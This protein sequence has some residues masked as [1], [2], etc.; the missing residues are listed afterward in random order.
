MKS[1][2]VCISP[3]LLHLYKLE[4]KIVVVVDILRA[5][6]CMTTAFANGV[7]SIIPVASLEE[8][9]EYKNK[10]F[11]AAAE[12]EGKTAEGFDLGNSPFSYMDSSFKGKTIVVTTTNGT[13]AITKSR[14]ATLVMIGS[15]LNKTAIIK[16][17]AKQERHVLVLCSGWRGSFNMEDTLFAG[18]LVSGLEGVYRHESDSALMAKRIYESARYNMMQ[19][20]EDSTHFKRLARLNNYKDIEFCLTED[21]YDILI[22]E[23]DGALVKL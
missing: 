5:T 9:M 3:D 21:L 7:Q 2:D 13:L 16:Y 23:K 11:L 12:R 22:A 10:G 14:A 4:E 20:L 15:F 19:Y 17:L 8:C 18:S 1:I 6:S